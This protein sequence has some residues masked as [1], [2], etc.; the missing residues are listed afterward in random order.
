M[1]AML[2]SRGY[3]G[4]LMP[5]K[6]R[7]LC[8]MGK[9]ALN[10][11]TSLSLVRQAGMKQCRDLSMVLNW[12][13]FTIQWKSRELS[14]KYV[15]LKCANGPCAQSMSFLDGHGVPAAYPSVYLAPI[16]C[17]SALLLWTGEA[18]GGNALWDMPQILNDIKE[19]QWNSQSW[20]SPF[21]GR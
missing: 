2:C 9:S 16:V 10:P 20:L 1:G 13:W 15:V 12:Q 19:G 21:N 5:F 8:T 6:L 3:Q 17:G 11:H 4:N 14:L 7:H 18:G